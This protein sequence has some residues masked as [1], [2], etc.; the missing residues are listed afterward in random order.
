MTEWAGVPM[1]PYLRIFWISNLCAYGTQARLILLDT[2][3]Q[4]IPNL[5]LLCGSLS[6]LANPEI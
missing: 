5:Y 4:F 2:L 3:L 6:I 1:P